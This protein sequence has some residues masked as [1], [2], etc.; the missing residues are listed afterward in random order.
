PQYIGYVFTSVGSFLELLVDLF[1]ADQLEDIVTVLDQPTDRPTG[2]AISLV[3]QPV[4]LHDPR[5]HLGQRPFLAQIGDG[6]GDLLRR[7]QDDVGQI[8]GLGARALD[9]VEQQRVG[10]GVN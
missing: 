7:G 6:G 8:F 5:H 9:A 2:D 10:G 1:P 4:D 3:L